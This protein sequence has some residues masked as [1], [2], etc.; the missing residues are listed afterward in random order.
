[1]LRVINSSAGSCRVE[2]RLGGA[3]LNPYAGF[4]CCL[5]AGIRG[6]RK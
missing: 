4:A 2:Y 5:G 6:M 1:M 3:D